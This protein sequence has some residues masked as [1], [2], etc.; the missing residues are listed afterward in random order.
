MKVGSMQARPMT[1]RQRQQIVARGRK[2]LKQVERGHW[3]LGDWY[4]DAID[5]G[6]GDGRR[7]AEDVHAD[8]LQLLN[9]GWVARSVKISLRR[10]NLS[11]SHHAAI[12]PLSPKQ[13]PYWLQQAE[14]HRWTLKELRQ[15]LAERKSRREQPLEHLVLK[16]RGK[17]ERFGNGRAT[18]YQGNCQDILSTL[19]FDVVVSDPPW[20]LNSDYGADRRRRRSRLYRYPQLFAA[21]PTQSLAAI[22]RAVHRRFWPAVWYTRR[23]VHLRL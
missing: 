13:Q 15:Q 20:G 3:A 21:P 19:Q 12:A 18:L 8:Y 1:D 9:W 14:R 23:G 2:L 10:E 11:W 17:I 6:Y 22:S 5:R 7:L 4:N 16:R